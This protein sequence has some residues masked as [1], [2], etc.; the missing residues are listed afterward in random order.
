MRFPS[1]IETLESRSMFSATAINHQFQTQSLSTDLSSIRSQYGVPSIT[2][3]T[4]KNGKVDSVATVGTRAAGSSVAATTSDKY[5]IG[6][7]TKAMTSTL[8]ARLIEKGYFKW[9][10]TVRDFFP[11]LKGYAA[12]RYGSVTLEQLLANRSGLPQDPTGAQTVGLAIDSGTGMKVRNDFLPTLLKLKPVVTPGDYSYSNVGYIVAGTMMETAMKES[13][14]AMMTRL[15]F[16][17]LGMTSASFGWPGS[18]STIDQPRATSAGGTSKAPNA[19]DKFP[20]AFDPSGGVATNITDWSKFIGVQLG[21]V[22]K[23]FLT[24]DSIKTL[25]RPFGGGSG[26]TYALGWNIV[27]SGFQD[28]TLLQHDGT[29]GYWYASVLASTD[30]DK[31]VLVLTNRGGAAGA[32]AAHAAIKKLGNKLVSASDV[33]NNI[34]GIIKHIF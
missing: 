11:G 28:F 6:S 1:C 27:D 10:S 15:V 2:A 34:G 30:T 14:E 31:A 7:A 16:K 4:M 19:I 8:A 17:P 26:S 24:T 5:L 23:K 18:S 12:K 33:T 29:D 13:Y 20:A 21:Q 9:T 32:G 22:P 3:A 25:R